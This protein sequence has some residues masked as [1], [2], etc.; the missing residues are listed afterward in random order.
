MSL[1]YRS[2]KTARFGLTGPVPAVIA[3][4]VHVISI[5]VK[6]VN[7]SETSERAGKLAATRMYPN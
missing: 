2:L 7:E 5:S 4:R 6:T 3:D 1:P